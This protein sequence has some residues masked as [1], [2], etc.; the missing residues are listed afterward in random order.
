MATTTF[1][2]YTGNGSNK[3]FN[4][5]FP[6]FT[7]SEVVVEVDGVVVDNFTIPSYQ[8]TGTRTVTFDSSTG[9]V[10]TNVCE[11]DGSPKNGLEVIVRRD[12]NVDAAKAS[13]TAGSSLKAADLT[14]NNLQILRALQEEQNSPVTT[15]RI[16]DGAITTA[17]IK[18]DNITNALIADDQIDSEHYVAGSID[19]E[20]MSANSVDSNQYVDGSIDEVHLANSAV[21]SNKIA[22]NAV[23]TTEILNGAVTRDKIA[24]DAIDGTKLADNAV[25]SE[26]Y[27]DGSIDRVHLEADIID[28]TKLADNAVNSEHYVDGSIDRVHLEADIIDSTKLADDAVGAEHIQANAVTD[29]EIATGTL[30]NRYFTETELTGGAL[31]GR[32]FTETESDARYFNV[33][34]GDTI[35]DGDSF[36]DNDTTI[37]TTAAI[38]DRIIDLV[39]D[40]GGFVPIANELSFPNTNP[41]VNNG[42]GTLVSIK[43]LSQNLTSNGSGVISISNGTVGNSTVTI[44]GA[45]NSTTYAATFGMIVETTTT[46]NTYTFHRLVPKATEVSTVSGSIG[47]INT[48][49][50]AISNVNAVAGNATNINTVAANNTNVTNV[51]SNI[52]NVNA[53]HANASNINTVAGIN[54]NVT[55]VAG[56]SSNVTTVAGNTSNINSAVSNA[57]NIN[58][59]VSNASNI[60]TV[61]GSIS[62][63]N[64]TATNIASVNTTA[65]NIANVNN[66]TDKYQIASNNP[67]T[68]GGGNALAAGDLYFNTSAN[69]LKVY[70]GSAWQGG[71][72]ASGSFAATTGNTFTGDNRYNDGVKAL[73]GTGSDLKIFHNGSHSYIKDSGTGSLKLLGDDVIITNTAETE[74]KARFHSDG[75]VELYY[76]NSKKIETTSGGATVTGNVFVTGS[77][78][79]DDNSKLDLGNSNDLQIYH[80][81]TNNYVE[82]INGVIHL[83]SNYGIQFDTTGSGNT[84]LRCKTSNNQLNSTTTSVELN[85]N[86]S[87]KFETTSTGVSVTGGLTASG[88]SEFTEDVKF[89]GSTAGRDILFDRSENK[90]HFADNAKAVFGES[91]DLQIYHE[92][93]DSWIRD[94]G[95]GRLLIDG[96]EVHIR[97]YAAA[98]TMAKFIEDGAVKLYFDNGL[99]LET[100]SS[101]TK[102]TGQ[103]L[104]YQGASGGT[105]NSGAGLTLEDDNHHYLQFLSPNNKEVGI[106]FGDDADNNAGYIAYSHS[107]NALAIGTNGGERV[108]VDSSGNL[109]IP[110]DSGKLQLGSGQDLEIYHNGTHSYIVDTGTG[111]LRLGTNTGI[112]LTKHDSET[113]ANFVPDGAVELYYDNSKKFETTNA[114]ITLNGSAH[115]VNSGNFYPN[116]DGAIQLGLSNRK[117]STING[118]SLNINGGDAQFRGT[119]P[120]TTDMTWDQSENALNFADNVY[121]HFGTGDDL[122]IYHD[123]SNSYINNDTQYLQIQS[124]YGVL[125]QRHDGSEN[126]LRALSNGAVELYYDGSKKF[127]TNSAGVHVLG[128]LEGDNFKAS[129]PGNNALLIQNPSNGIIGFGA[130]NQSNQVTI[131]T[132]G[133]LG[134]PNDSGK[135]RL[136]ASEDLQLY[137]DGSHSYVNASGTGALKLLGN[138]NDDVQIQPRSG[139]NSGRF[140]PNGA[141]ELY[142][143]NSK[144]FETTTDG[145]DVD[146]SITCNDLVTAGAVLH[147][148][149]TNTLMHFDQ[150]DNIAFKTNGTVRFRIANGANTS[151][152]DLLPSV[153]NGK[154]LGSSSTRWRNVYTNDLHL[155]NEGSSNDVDGTWGNWTIQE[156][157]SDLFL[158]NN[159]SGKKYK[160]N[161][162]EV[163]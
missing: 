15:P 21:T 97:K 158:K 155:S 150:A 142:Y 83:R 137:H 140:K 112:R 104:I 151:S 149:D 16:R 107:T 94:A 4:Y 79:G 77:F 78:R 95:T 38:N 129:N 30:D 62:N 123:G 148:N 153:N 152:S 6:T 1:Q 154:D 53:V 103:Q 17:K 96:S 89:D 34:T 57:S 73:F 45:A 42:A 138:N 37:A 108:K 80:N 91:S 20:H 54:A 119:T 27:T 24:A 69:E 9:T 159:R 10:N 127:E 2:P 100:T 58:S 82:S 157:E 160:F 75:N 40:V 134:I 117:W 109:Q 46:L 67:S 130:N 162:T 116:S 133:H 11:S 63:V 52:S 23:T 64:T 32:Y 76:D 131:T 49:G 118:V 110:N 19:L 114:G 163:S 7:A 126:L 59:A 39:D 128:T 14:N 120:G 113:L 66:F 105:A 101:G 65:S 141:V 48:V 93:S 36:P 31:D 35:K 106:L 125:L 121:A 147:E 29:S 8:T 47:N 146:G 98:E 81:G 3:T 145:I 41:D 5:S 88:S 71:V 28:S 25:D 26:H 55:T 86:N 136:G 135:L 87:K 72:T 102:I 74:N 132:D 144:K 13:Y 85:Y 56:I 84:W 161:L 124:S 122:K 111:E 61:A 12:T 70:N 115:L 139:Y 60:N 33:S 51:G 68:D 44:T 18:A 156:G 99:K 90:F 143:D 22:D 43:S 92:G 50:N